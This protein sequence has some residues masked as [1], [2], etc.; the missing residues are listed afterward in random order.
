MLGV[1]ELSYCLAVGSEAEGAAAVN[2]TV[3]FKRHGET[4]N[5][6]KKLMDNLLYRFGRFL[7]KLDHIAV[8]RE[9]AGIHHIQNVVLLTQL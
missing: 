1:H 2:D 9:T 3:L 4:I 8:L 7:K 5:A 6:L